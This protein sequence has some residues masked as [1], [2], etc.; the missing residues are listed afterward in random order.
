MRKQ[1]EYDR[2]I[3]LFNISILIEFMDI[4]TFNGMDGNWAL[5][6]EWIEADLLLNVNKWKPAYLLADLWK[7]II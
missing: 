7:K 2:I 5:C 3:C 4:N 6:E 1:L